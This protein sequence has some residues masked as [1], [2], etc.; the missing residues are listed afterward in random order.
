[1]PIKNNSI[2]HSISE[3]RKRIE[4]IDKAIKEI[5]TIL[6]NDMAIPMDSAKEINK[7]LKTIQEK[8]RGF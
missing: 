3:K 8:V 2:V 1:M 5:Q 7:S 4:E 6:V